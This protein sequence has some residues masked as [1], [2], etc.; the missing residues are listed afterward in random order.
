MKASATRTTIDS[1]NRGID[2][3]EILAERG[4][5]RL[6]E[7]PELLGV[8]RAT[9]FRVLRTLRD[10][11]YIDHVESEHVYRLGPGPTLLGSRSQ[12]G[13]VARLADFALVQLRDQTGETA[14]LALLQGGDL[15]YASILESNYALRTSAA[16]GE[17]VPLHSTALGKAILSE[18]PAETARKMAGAE[19]YAQPTENAPATWEELLAHLALTRERG[20]GIDNQETDPGATCIAAAITDA[21]GYP[22]GGLSVS[23]ATS[24]I[25][26]DRVSEIAGTLITLCAELSEE[27]NRLPGARASYK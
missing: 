15:I 2:L 8:S 25:S 13:T 4:S 16:V 11:G 3:L 1:L 24:R 21:T 27:L 14:N 6:A 19:P 26:A 12:A 5:V 22:L 20:Y 18:L 7:L 23:G 9:A 17:I 10:R